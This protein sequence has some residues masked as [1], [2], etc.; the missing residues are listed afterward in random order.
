MTK[1]IQKAKKGLRASR[2]PTLI[3]TL[4]MNRSSTLAVQLTIALCRGVRRNPGRQPPI[5]SCILEHFSQLYS[6]GIVHDA[7]HNRCKARNVLHYTPLVL[8]SNDVFEKPGD[9]AQLDRPM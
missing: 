5:V 9:P 7:L 6:S 1:V 8:A 4:T 2:I 3:P